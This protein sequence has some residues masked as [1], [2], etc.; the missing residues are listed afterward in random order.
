MSGLFWRMARQGLG[1]GLQVIDD[2]RT[3][4]IEEPY[5]RDR[6]SIILPPEMHRDRIDWIL[7]LSAL[8]LLGIGLLMV[9]SS[10]SFTA[11]TAHGNPFGRFSA[12]SLR[13]FV[14]L[15]LLF[16]ASRMDYRW[17][18]TWSPWIAIGSAL[19]L[20]AVFLPGIGEA[21]KGSQ[22]WLEVGPVRFQP[23]E[24]ARVGLIVYLARLLSKSPQ[25]IERFTTG[26]LPAFLAAGVFMGLI[27]VQPSL[28]SALT[29]ALTT[30]AMCLAAGMKRQ[31][32]LLVCLVGVIGL[33]LVLVF[34]SESYQVQRL[35]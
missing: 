19:L 23:I 9:L 18:S 3:S 31:H 13:G 28:G 17:L 2:V 10:T 12:Q 14:G 1:S 11:Q 33:T 30:L 22:R 5:T 7:L 25:K 15:V 27:I 16:V 26:P 4:I 8:S 32:F 20:A 29:L 6:S 24:L 34:K 35:M 21:S